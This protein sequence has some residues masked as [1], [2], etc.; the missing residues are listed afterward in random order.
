MLKRRFNLVVSIFVAATDSVV[1]F[2]SRLVGGKPKTCMVLAYHSVPAEE[3]E[4]FAKQMDVLKR[5][6][7]PVPANVAALPDKA[8][9][10]VAITFDDGLETVFDNAL[11]ELRKRGIHSTLFIVPEVLGGHPNWE[12]FDTPDPSVDQVMT[13]KQLQEIPTDLVEIGSHSMTHPVLPKVDD[14]GLR[15]ELIGSREAL[16]KMLNREI[17]L[18]S[19]P[20]GAFDDR[21]AERC[22][23]AKY[24]RIFSALPVPAFVK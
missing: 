22:R 1:N 8:G 17:K 20:Y 4:L 5:V 13:V 7:T 12:F 21:V 19:F 14:E 9:R 2:L 3:R 24:D 6:A 18:F 23:E 11:P 15:R 16:E 10:Y